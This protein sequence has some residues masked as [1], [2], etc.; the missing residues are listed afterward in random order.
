MVKFI[1]KVSLIF[2]K[3]E[4]DTKDRLTAGVMLAER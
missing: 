4:N 3:M 2:N 1:I